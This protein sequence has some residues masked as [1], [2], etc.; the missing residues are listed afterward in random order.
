MLNALEAKKLRMNCSSLGMLSTVGENGN[1]SGS[2]G[3]G[4]RFRQPHCAFGIVSSCMLDWA[5]ILAD[6]NPSGSILRDFR[7]VSERR[8]PRVFS[9]KYMI[10]LV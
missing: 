4:R 1:S 6:G 5:L 8:Q 3:G 10:W 7:A 2:G 9:A